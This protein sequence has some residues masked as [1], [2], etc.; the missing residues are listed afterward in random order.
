MPKTHTIIYFQASKTNLA[1]ILISKN[2]NSNS[3]IST[4][5]IRRC[6]DG[7]IKI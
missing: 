7:H 3:M 5:F 4:I 2:V 6:S 1:Q